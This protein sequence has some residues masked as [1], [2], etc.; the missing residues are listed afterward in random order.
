MNLFILKNIFFTFVLFF[1]HISI[2]FSTISEGEKENRVKP[3]AEWYEEKTF[4]E[5]FFVDLPHLEAKEFILCDRAGWE[6]YDLAWDTPIT[7]EKFL[8]LASLS[9]WCLTEK[10]DCKSDEEESEDEDDD[11][12]LCS[13]ESL[14][15]ISFQGDS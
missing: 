5:K 1:F 14:V 8:Q 7:E 9:S 6:I 15:I 3:S 10:D 4:K 11:W 12:S 13:F 2:V